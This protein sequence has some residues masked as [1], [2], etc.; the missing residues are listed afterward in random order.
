MTISEFNNEFTVMVDKIDGP[1]DGHL[2]SIHYVITCNANKLFYFKE[3]FCDDQAFLDTA[4]STRLFQW[5][6]VQDASSIQAWANSVRYSPSAFSTYIPSDVP[7]IGVTTFNNSF[8]VGIGR[9]EPYP[10]DDP[11]VIV[12]NFNVQMGTTGDAFSIESTIPIGTTNSQI[13]DIAWD[14]VKDR[15][16]AIAQNKFIADPIIGHVIVPDSF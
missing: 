2:A 14:T 8:S 11:T 13:L 9:Y 10:I 16:G 12:V 6:F 15:I 7:L 5:A 4:T 3:F 1:A